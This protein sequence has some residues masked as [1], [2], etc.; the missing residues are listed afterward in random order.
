MLRLTARNRLRPSSR[1]SKYFKERSTINGATFRLYKIELRARRIIVKKF[2]SEHKEMA[3]RKIINSLLRLE[4]V[5][6]KEQQRKLYTDVD[7]LQQR[8]IDLELGFRNRRF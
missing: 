3:S 7:E 1:G 6:L 8:K 4:A 5:K 2:C